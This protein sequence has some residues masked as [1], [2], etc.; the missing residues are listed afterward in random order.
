MIQVPYSVEARSVSLQE[1]RSLYFGRGELP[2]ALVD[3]SVLRSWERCRQAGLN[4]ARL[5]CGDPNQRGVVEA[6]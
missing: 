3:Q 6:R 2:E 5:E 1:A 4:P